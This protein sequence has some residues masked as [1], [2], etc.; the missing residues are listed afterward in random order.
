[1]MVYDDAHRAAATRARSALAPLGADLRGHVDR[2]RAGDL[3]ARSQ[4]T[5]VERIAIPSRRPQ[6]RAMGERFAPGVRCRPHRRPRLITDYYSYNTDLSADDKSHPRSAARPWFQPHWVGDL[7]LSLR[8]T[9]HEPAG[10]FRLETDQGRRFQ[11]LRDRPGERRGSPFSWRRPTGRGSRD[12]HHAGW[13]ARSRIRQR[14]RPADALGRWPSAVRNGTDLRFEPG[15]TAADRRR[16]RAGSNRRARCLGR[17]RQAR[18]QARPLLHART[19]RVRLFQPGRV[20][21][22][23]IVGAARIARRPGAVPQR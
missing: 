15:A 18:P 1:M 10:Q 14:R 17:S 9:V 16:S 4:R 6:P 22:R 21:P 3:C 23:R 19:C 12:G 7:T 2:S 20:G 13:R 11:S 5:G 8:L